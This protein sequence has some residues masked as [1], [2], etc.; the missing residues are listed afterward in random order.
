VI[1]VGQDEDEISLVFLSPKFQSIDSEISQED[2]DDSG[3]DYEDE[4][5]VSEERKSEDQIH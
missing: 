5:W 2:E 3:P 4:D 1:E